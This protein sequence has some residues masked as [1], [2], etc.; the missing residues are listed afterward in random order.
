MPENQD[1]NIFR[2]ETGMLKRVESIS[3]SNIY[4]FDELMSEY[5][6]LGTEYQK[7]LKQTKKLVRIS[8][9]TQKELFNTREELQ[10]QYDYIN[11]ELIRASEH[12]RSLLPS[13]YLDD[14]LR[15][16]WI[17]QPSSKL[18]GDIFGYQFADDSH[19]IVY[20]IDV[21]GHG[22]GPAL[23]SVSV[24][25]T[26]RFQTL[27]KTDFTDPSEVVSSL[28]N[29]F[30][31]FDHN[32]L[33]FTMWYC[34]I[35]IKTGIMR[36]TGAGHPPILIINRDK[37][38]KEIFSKNPPVGTAQGLKYSSDECLLKDIEYI[39]MFTD[40]VYEIRNQAG[41]YMNINLFKQFLLDRLEVETNSLEDILDFSINYSFNNNLED[42]FTLL[43]ISMTK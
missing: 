15:I 37:E 11:V 33:Y 1:D 27:P 25:N 26:I 19:L 20:L 30:S 14:N 39:Y 5:S 41:K 24:Y 40:G 34:V 31:M 16:D 6:V 9:R 32:H 28:N 23:H 13:P 4:D 21:C 38:L 17:Y 36:Y 12:V 35:N 42:D 18:G 10:K 2:K 29:T 43:E 3:K 8:D 22:I 7:L